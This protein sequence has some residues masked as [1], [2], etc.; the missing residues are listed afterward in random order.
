MKKNKP[1][2]VLPY[3]R[4]PW[5]SET[6]FKKWQHAGLTCMIQRNFYG[7]WCGY[8]GVKKAHPCY[9]KDCGRISSGYRNISAH[10]GV[11]YAGRL[12]NTAIWWIGFGCDSASDIIPYCA[13]LYEATETIYGFVGKHGEIYRD[14]AYAIKETNNLA[15]QLASLI[16]ES[17][18]A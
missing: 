2:K 4:G 16:K 18:H 9:E 14:T 8:V 10:G 5:D 6:N 3:S 17:S 1:K 11:T 15:E 13:D 7:V 12:D